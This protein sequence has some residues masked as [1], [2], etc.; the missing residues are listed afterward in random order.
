MLWP[1]SRIVL[2]E[3]DRQGMISC[4]VRDDLKQEDPE[5]VS[6]CTWLSILDHIFIYGYLHWNGEN[7]FKRISTLTTINV[8]TFI[9]N[10]SLGSSSCLKMVCAPRKLIMYIDMR[11]LTGYSY[12]F[13][14]KW[15]LIRER[16]EHMDYGYRGCIACMFI[17]LKQWVCDW[18]LCWNQA[19]RWYGRWFYAFGWMQLLRTVLWHSMMQTEISFVYPFAAVETASWWK[20]WFSFQLS[21]ITKPW[22][23]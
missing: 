5:V 18:R 17:G 21:T 20:C 13:L 9:P 10:R 7:G 4:I 6:H 2:I 8:A 12:T 22:K 16:K 19:M 3:A 15:N 11:I 1:V 23:I 14:K